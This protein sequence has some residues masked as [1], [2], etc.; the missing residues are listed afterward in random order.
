MAIKRDIKFALRMQLKKP[1]FTAVAVLTLALGVGANTAIF[2]LVNAIFIKSL[3][4]GAPDRLVLLFE[5]TKQGWY[6][7]A[8]PN[9]LDW[10]QMNRSFEEMACFRSGHRVLQAAAGAEKLSCKWVSANFFSTLGVS[11]GLGRSIHQ[12]RGFS[13]RRARRCSR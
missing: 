2:S 9:Y 6:P 1:G 4:F 7:A 3:P 10:R 5:S 8:Y 12:A 13:G 11:P